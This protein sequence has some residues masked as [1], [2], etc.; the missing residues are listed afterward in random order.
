MG[1]DAMAVGGGDLELGV[2]HLVD[3]A[4]KASFAV[5]SANLISRESGLPVFSP[6]VVIQRAGVRV[7]VLGLTEDTALDQAPDGEDYEIL[8]Y[9]AT[10]STYIDDVAAQSDVIVL[11]SHIGLQDDRLLA[12]SFDAIDVIVGGRN[13]R[14][15]AAPEIVNGTTIVQLGARGEDLGK[16]E[17]ALD[18]HNRPEAFRWQV[19]ALGPEFTDDPQVAALVHRYRAAALSATATP[20]ESASQ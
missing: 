8:S 11:L 5:L 2:A 17:I 9:D 15:M 18:S 6:Y 20:G 12:E 4:D 16:I 19:I 3:Q 13:A 14:R 10:V 7:G 1:Y